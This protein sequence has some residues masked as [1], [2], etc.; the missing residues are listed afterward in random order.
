MIREADVT[1]T[2]MRPVRWISQRL[3]QPHRVGKVQSSKQQSDD[4]E[5]SAK[6]KCEELGTSLHAPQPPTKPA[7]SKP[8]IPATSDP[9][10]TSELLNGCNEF[11]LTWIRFHRMGSFGHG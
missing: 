8:M 4:P 10:V 6:S 5:N 1:T 11:T 2:A 7:P 9:M 3:G